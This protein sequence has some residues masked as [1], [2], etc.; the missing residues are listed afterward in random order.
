[1]SRLLFGTLNANGMKSDS[2]RYETART[3]KNFRL[4]IV[5]IQETGAPKNVDCNHR[6]LA[7]FGCPM[8]FSRYCALAVFNPHIQILSSVTHL[9]GH[10]LFISLSFQTINFSVCVIYAPVASREK[11][12]F[13]TSLSEMDWPSSSIFLGDFNCFS[14][15][16]LDHYPPSLIQKPGAPAFNAFK[17][18]A[19]LFDTFSLTSSSLQDMT[20]VVSLNNSNW[21]SGTRIDHILV[22]RNLAPLFTIPS[23]FKVSCS[24]HRLVTSYWNINLKYD[25]GICC[26]RPLFASNPQLAAHILSDVYPMIAHPRIEKAPPINVIWSQVKTSVSNIASL[27]AKERSAAFLKAYKKSAAVLQHLERNAPKSF[28]PSWQS[29]YIAAQGKFSRLQRSKVDKATLCALEKHLDDSETMSPYFLRSFASKNSI[30]KINAIKTT[31]SDN[32]SDPDIISRSIH[33]FY[34]NLYAPSTVSEEACKE[35]LNLSSPCSIPCSDWDTL[36][37]PISLDEVENVVSKFPR[38]KASGPDGIPHE[39]YAANKAL[40]CPV[41]VE[42]FN[43][44]LLTGTP[45]PGGNES[46]IVLLFKKGEREDLKNWRPIS[47]A[48]TDYKILTKILNTRVIKFASR[49]ITP[50]QYGFLPGRS[51]WENTFQVNNLLMSKFRTTNGYVLFLDMEKAYDR[52]NWDFL[53]KTLLHYGFPNM[54]VTWIQTLYSNLQAKVITSSGLTEVFDICQGL[55]Q[56]DPMSPTLF[57]FVIDTFLYALQSK[58]IG[59]CQGDNSYIK[60]VAFADDTVVTIGSATDLLAFKSAINLYQQASNAKLNNNKTL[61]VKVGNPLF[62]IS[63][64]LIETNTPF[65]HLG[66]LFSTSGAYFGANESHLLSSIQNVTTLWCHRQISLTGRCVAAN[67]FLLSKIIYT[68]HIVPF[69]QAFFD[70]LYRILQKWLWPRYK[71]APVSITSI[72]YPRRCGGMG[73]INPQSLCDRML[74]KW[75][76]PI[77]SPSISLSNLSW[78]QLAR[79]NWNRALGFSPHNNASLQKWLSSCPSR[80]PNSLDLYWKRCLVSIHR[81]GLEVVDSTPPGPSRGF[82]RLQFDLLW[83]GK[84]L[85]SLPL[86]SLNTPNIQQPLNLYRNISNLPSN[87]LVWT[88]I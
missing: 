45:I 22:S 18:A 66:V 8:V 10:V 65:R 76:S 73:L 64:N 72:M 28:S 46:R 80:G 63:Y 27:R 16:Y 49:L 35:I 47:L 60:T 55:R 42:L 53:T 5:G 30:H 25:R 39:L 81:S 88:F 36:V 4:D 77:L 84:P 20:R 44:C 41:L 37:Q 56:G 6:W 58:L 1:M 69:S 9:D 3:L 34:S 50:C 2:R 83:Q 62:P 31:S 13:F 43:F 67:V 7:P 33:Q 26:I 86:P 87:D 40:F 21:V 52:V 23:T 38:K 68:A 15:P 75:I 24:D 14:D 85:N 32:S 79:Y 54:F 17:L 71:K 78:S 57:N 70:S 51:I 59:I 61:A 48:N 82:K 29:K 19:D 12:D 74:L 11:V